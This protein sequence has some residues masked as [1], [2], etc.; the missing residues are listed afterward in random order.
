MKKLLIVMLTAGLAFAY[1]SCSKDSDPV[2]VLQGEALI[3][4]IVSSNAIEPVSVADLPNT[5]PDY[6]D[7][8]HA[9]FNIEDASLM[10]NLGFEVMLENGLCI[11]FDT[12]GHHINHEGQHD[13]FDNYHGW[14]HPGGPHCMIGDTLDIV[15]LPTTASN[16]IGTNFPGQLVLT[17]IL[18]PSG[19]LGVELSN[20]EVL[21]FTPNGD[22]INE[23][24]D[25]NV[26]NHGHDH[27][28]GGGPWHCNPNDMSPHG[29]GMGQG[30]HWHHSGTNGN[31]LTPPGPNEPCWG[32]AGFNIDDLPAVIGTYVN[33]H[34]PDASIISAIQTYGDLYL[35]RL[36]NCVRLVFDNQGNILF[37]SGG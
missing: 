37:D 16:Y 9:P 30:G 15:S 8:I 23:C 13:D 6:V 20:S 22:F 34:Y 32:G 10:P 24:G 1:F 25:L 31:I 28:I 18:K 36:S 5:I 11:F 14:T 35:L 21:M 2:V 19:I 4:Q 33:V 3:Q 29:G 27:G 17:V 26:G 12:D 7:Q